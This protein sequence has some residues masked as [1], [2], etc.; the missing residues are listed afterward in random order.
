[1][2]TEVLGLGPKELDGFMQR[3]RTE[4]SAFLKRALQR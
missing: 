1:M 4:L 3:R 2:I